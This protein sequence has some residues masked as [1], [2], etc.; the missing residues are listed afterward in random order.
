MLCA[1]DWKAAV[2]QDTGTELHSREQES[3]YS[4]A[5][6]VLTMLR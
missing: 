3:Q 5:I 6:Y 1:D 2:H 4:A